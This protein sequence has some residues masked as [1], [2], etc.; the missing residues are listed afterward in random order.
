MTKSPLLI[1]A[2]ALCIGFTACNET[3]TSNTE[4]GNVEQNE[5]ENNKEA[6]ATGQYTV[7]VSKSVVE[8]KGTMVG[9]YHHTGIA[10]FQKGKISLEN[11]RI[12]QGTF[13]VDMNSLEAT[14]ENYNPEEGN[15]K[16]KL[17]Q[18]LKSDDFFLVEEYPTASFTLT[19]F[20]GE[21]A[22]GT[23]TIR[24]TEGEVTVKDLDVHAHDGELHITGKT[25]FDRRH[26]GVEFTHPLEE[27]VVADEVEL[28][29][30]ITATQQ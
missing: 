14:D 17:I 29:I 26:Y 2:F 22:T 7:D 5:A 15:T 27:M 19:Q 16:E 3:G 11:G 10:K 21:T 6:A 20:D 30:D 18:H 13:V 25:S 24:G 4:T 1:G 8:W 9:V 23:M 12:S 28:N